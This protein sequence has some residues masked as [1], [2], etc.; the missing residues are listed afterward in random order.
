MKTKVEEIVLRTRRRG[1][2]NW[3]LQQAIK[4]PNCIIISKNA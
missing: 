1:N 2:T 4:N 3:I